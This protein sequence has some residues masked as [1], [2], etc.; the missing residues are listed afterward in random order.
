MCD[1]K[2]YQELEWPVTLTQEHDDG[3]YFVATIK[4]MPGLIAT[5]ETAEEA[6]SE[7]KD[8]SKAWLVAA[9]EKGYKITEP[10]SSD[11]YKNFSGKISLRM[12]KTLHSRLAKMAKLE[13]TSLNSYINYII[14]LG[15]EN[16]TVYENISIESEQ[17]KVEEQYNVIANN[18]IKL[19]IAS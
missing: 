18:I 9:F 5:G 13:E 6:I 7:A 15:I 11:V 1:L 10:D 8:A 12:P 17:Y 19:P 3:D 16:T 2:Y 4:E 14:G